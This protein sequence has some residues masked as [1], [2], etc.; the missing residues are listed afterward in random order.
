MIN[1][2]EELFKMQKD[3]YDKQLDSFMKLMNKDMGM[4][5]DLRTYMEE[6]SNAADQ[7]YALY[8]KLY[9]GSVKDSG[10]KAKEIFDKSLEIT[11]NFYK[12]TFI[13]SMPKGYRD[14]L[15][16]LGV[17]E[18][19]KPYIKI[20]KDLYKELNFTVPN[21][22]FL[23][24]T[25]EETGDKF[26][27]QVM[28]MPMPDFAKNYLKDA[29]KNYKHVY[30]LV[31]SVTKLQVYFLE[32]SANTAKA[33]TDRYVDSIDQ[34]EDPKSMEEFYEFYKKSINLEYQKMINSDEFKQI[35]TEIKT[36]FDINKETLF[37]LMEYQIRNFPIVTN[38]KIESLNARVE[39]V[40]TKLSEIEQN[41]DNIKLKKEIE[42]L[43][44]ENTRLK[45]KV[46]LLDSSAEI[47]KIKEELKTLQTE[48]KNLKTELEKN[49]SDKLEKEIA[50]LKA[51]LKEILESKK[52]MEAS[53]KKAQASLEKFTK[54]NA[55]LKRKIT[56]LEKKDK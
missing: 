35:T 34:K 55:N 25:F 29:E 12:R 17:L 10:D 7:M 1:Y 36:Y 30:E 47:G 9:R 16:T 15:N 45:D 39:A 5:M 11:F 37:N 49:T 44:E 51:S 23:M 3:F 8:K 19:V 18:Y 24:K 46:N 40:S 28:E 43:K 26:M 27:K 41:K 22:D 21:K 52:E 14:M 33:I 48:N 42:L 13:D 6:A 32:Y 2:Y 56:L 31:K 4:N 20:Q 50:E 53:V 54:D 38:S